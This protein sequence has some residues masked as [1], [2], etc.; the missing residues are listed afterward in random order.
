[1]HFIHTYARRHLVRCEVIYGTPSNY[2]LSLIL[3]LFYLMFPENTHTNTHTPT[4]YIFILHL[5]YLMS[6]SRFCTFLTDISRQHT[7]T[8]FHT[9]PHCLCLFV[10]VWVLERSI[11]RLAL[12]LSSSCAV[13]L[14]FL[15]P[16]G[17]PRQ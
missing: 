10:R 17:S 15:R 8:H 14:W 12:P 4:L 13:P 9:H 3:V 1:M 5:S 2:L 11:L 7:H 16:L 6:V